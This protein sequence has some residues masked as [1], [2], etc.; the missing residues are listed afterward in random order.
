MKILTDLFKLARKAFVKND[1][2]PMSKMMGVTPRGDAVILMSGTAIN[3][4]RSTPHVRVELPLAVYDLPALDTSPDTIVA[5]AQK[6]TE[7]ELDENAH[8]SERAFPSF[9]SLVLSDFKALTARVS[10][11]ALQKAAA[12]MKDAKEAFVTI[13]FKE[14]P[15]GPL[16]MFQGA[17]TTVI[18]MGQTPRKETM[19]VNG[20]EGEIEEAP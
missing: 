1:A 14:T 7:F 3:I 10:V 16:F 6:Q 12:S 2:H 8:Y 9:E 18:V 17:K 19:N 11:T 5:L 13:G 20:I 15:N 4:F